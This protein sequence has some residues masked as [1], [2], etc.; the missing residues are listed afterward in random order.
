[1]IKHMN[2]IIMGKTGVGKST[3]VNSLMG[4][5]VAETGIGLPVTSENKI[6]ERIFQINTDQV[7]LRIYDTVGIELNSQTTERTLS[8]VKKHIALIN[9]LNDLEERK[10]SIDIIW[11]C[12]HS[13]SARFEKSEEKMINSLMFDYEIPFVIVFT[14]CWNPKNARNLQATIEQQYPDL[15]LVYRRLLA[16]KYETDIGDVDPYGLPELLWSSIYNY[17]YFKI[18]VLQDKLEKLQSD[19]YEKARISRM[20]LERKTKVAKRIVWI[21][22]DKAFKIGCVPGASL[23]ALQSQYHIMCN[24][25]FAAFE[26]ELDEDA[27]IEIAA[28]W[29]TGLILSP[30]FAIPGLSGA[31]AKEMIKEG[32][33]A[34]VDAVATVLRNSS[35][36]SLSDSRLMVQRITDEIEKRK[37]G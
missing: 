34:F 13:E 18:G 10:N 4:N 7:F 17:E 14:Q 22:A 25:I 16:E 31:I 24:E 33:N 26:L 2:L 32:G 36:D 8:E 21:R 6:Y 35:E 12:I 29:I 30:F 15:K 28:Y 9:Q 1:M 23:V 3:L 19:Q 20:D 37:R 11:Y 27:K 5:R